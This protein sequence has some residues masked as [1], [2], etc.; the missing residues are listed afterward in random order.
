MNKKVSKTLA[1]VLSAAMAA[2]AFAVSTGA[3]FAAPNVSATIAPEEVGI[4]STS[5]NYTLPGAND[6]GAWKDNVTLTVDGVE[7]DPDD[8][9]VTI[10]DK[11]QGW[12]SQNPALATADSTGKVKIAQQSNISQRQDVTFTREVSIE[13]TTEDGDHGTSKVTVGSAQLEMTVAIYP[14]GYY[15]VL[16]RY[17]VDT[18]TVGSVVDSEY[19]I[20]INQMASVDTYKATKDSSSSDKVSG[21]MPISLMKLSPAATATLILLLLARMVI[22]LPRILRMFIRVKRPFLWMLV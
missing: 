7:I 22:L 18:A 13:V 17:V 12:V 15:F 6:L 5:T 11:G 16:P 4:T 2:S 21:N 10:T 9:N 19:T 1:A 3:A 8:S 20:G 14:E